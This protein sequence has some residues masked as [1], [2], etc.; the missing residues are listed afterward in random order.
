MTSDSAQNGLHDEL[1]N[2][3]EEGDTTM[4]H[5]MVESVKNGAKYILIKANYT[6]LYV[7]LCHSKYALGLHVN[8]FMA[9]LSKKV[10]TIDIY[11]TATLLS[12]ITPHLLAL[13][14]CHYWL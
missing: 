9:L 14:T 12:N 2:L 8:I 4:I 3:F 7:L 5:H 13:C 10:K 11:K 6:D 1:R